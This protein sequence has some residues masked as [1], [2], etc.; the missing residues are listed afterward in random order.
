MLA[1]FTVEEFME[2]L[3]KGT[4]MPG[5]GSVAAMSGSAAA[6]L[7]AMVC[8]L[9]VG[10]KGYESVWDEL[11]AIA[12]NAVSAGKELLDGMDADAQA[13]QNVVNCFKLPKGTEAEAQAR[14]EA[15]QTETKKAAAV[16]LH[17]AELAMHLFDWAETV[18]EK[19]N[20]NAVSDGAIAA[21]L[22]KNSVW[23]ALYNVEINAV[24]LKDENERERLLRRSGELR[25]QSASREEAVLALVQFR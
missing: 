19:G 23:S 22:A 11:H 1:K 16:P 9:T 24:L 18:V 3:S 15:I 13:Y 25:E 21:M 14:A 5:G 2:E 17:T 12:E 10:K 8:N 20:R 6:N 7:I 4:P